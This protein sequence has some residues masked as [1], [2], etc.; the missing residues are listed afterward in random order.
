LSCRG[1]RVTGVHPD[2]RLLARARAAAHDQKVHLNLV[3]STSLERASSSVDL[4]TVMHGLHLMDPD[5]T[6]S[7][8]QKL[9]KKDGHLVAAFNDR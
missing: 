9:L 2:E 3:E 5:A 8:V 6:L 4:V 7:E 1:F